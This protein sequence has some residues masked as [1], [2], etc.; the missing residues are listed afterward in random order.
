MRPR[1]QPRAV[2]HGFMRVGCRTDN[3]RTGGGF[4]KDRD[5]T[6]RYAQLFGRAPGELLT[7]LTITRHDTDFPRSGILI[8]LLGTKLLEFQQFARCLL[9]L[10]SR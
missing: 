2:H 9:W 1:I 8:L 7:F 10:R 4:T 3:V 5:G 6:G